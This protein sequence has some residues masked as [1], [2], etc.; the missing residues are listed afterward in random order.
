MEVALD[1]MLQNDGRGVLYFPF[2]NFADGNLDSTRVML[3]SPAT[4][5][6]LSDGGAH[7]GMICDGSFPTSLLT[8]WGRD[9]LRGPGL[10][11]E[12]LISKQSRDT[13]HWV[14][15]HDRGVLKPGYRAD[16]NVID[17]DK[18]QLHL[19]EINYD[20]PSGGRRLM[21]RASGYT[22]TL[23]AGQVIYRDGTPTGAKPGKLVRGA[24]AAPSQNLAAE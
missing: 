23:V 20:L 10:P 15:L 9:R 14:G 22:A 16:I 4:L 5:P 21:Q 17:F 18:L 13:A 1:L 2:L 24:Q 12:L 7:V 3:Q 6:G 8:H 11:L 19:P